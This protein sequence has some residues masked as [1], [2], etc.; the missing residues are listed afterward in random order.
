M[1]L[2]GMIS[3]SEHAFNDNKNSTLNPS[4]D[5]DQSRTDASTKVHQKFCINL[6]LTIKNAKESNYCIKEI[7][8]A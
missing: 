2:F 3:Y 6:C 8:V 7:Y 5:L 1:V 4:G